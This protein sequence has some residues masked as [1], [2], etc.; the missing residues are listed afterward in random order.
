MANP[1]P[2]EN[3][4]YTTQRGTLCIVVADGIIYMVYCCIHASLSTLC[5]ELYHLNQLE[6]GLIYLPFG[7]GRILSTFVSGRILGR[8]YRVIALAHNLPVKKAQGDDMLRFPIE[9]ARTRSLF[10]PVSVTTISVICFAWTLQGHVVHH[11]LFQG[12]KK[13]ANIDPAYRDSPDA[14]TLDRIYY[15]ILLQC[16]Y[17]PLLYSLFSNVYAAIDLLTEC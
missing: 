16:K 5:I 9:E 15:T 17:F 8:D 6:A 12:S 14:P 10:V 1:Q 3:F 4:T 7:V 13:H 11:S 2:R